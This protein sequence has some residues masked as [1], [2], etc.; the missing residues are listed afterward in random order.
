MPYVVKII[1]NYYSHTSDTPQT[2]LLRWRDIDHKINNDD[3]AEYDTEAEAEAAISEIEGDEAY[4]LDHDEAGQTSYEIIDTSVKDPVDGED[5][6]DATKILDDNYMGDDMVM[7]D[8]DDLSDGVQTD[9]DKCNVQY[10]DSGDD[11]D[12]YTDTIRIDGKRYC[13]AYCPKTIAL[14]IAGKDLG[15]VNW[16][17]PAYFSEID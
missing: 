16:D 6:Y 13:I 7:I 10:A 8:P 11:Y 9:L 5:C 3:I 4:Y 12:I 2:S 14:Q 1:P 17:H 15:N